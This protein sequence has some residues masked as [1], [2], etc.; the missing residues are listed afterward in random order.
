MADRNIGD[1][2]GKSNTDADQLIT[3]EDVQHFLE[4]MKSGL[5]L[6]QSKIDFEISNIDK[7]HPFQGPDFYEVLKL[8]SLLKNQETGQFTE[9]V[10]SNATISF[11][12][13]P[14]AD[15][16]DKTTITI[17]IKDDFLKSVDA[18]DNSIITDVRKFHII[19]TTEASELTSLTISEVNQ[20]IVVNDTLYYI[21]DN[22]ASSVACTVDTLT[23][24]E[25]YTD[26]NFS[27]N[28]SK[29]KNVNNMGILL[30]SNG[31]NKHIPILK[32]HLE[33]AIN[34][35]DNNL[36][37]DD[38]EFS[39]STD[40]EE[41]LVHFS[42]K[43]ASVDTY[44]KQIVVTFPRAKV[45]NFF[46][47]HNNASVLVDKTVGYAKVYKI[48]DTI[49][50]TDYEL[51]LPPVF[52]NKDADTVPHDINFGSESVAMYGDYIAVS[53][54]YSRPID[55]EEHQP[56]TAKVFLYE[57]VVQSDTADPGY[58][59][60]SVIEDPDFACEPVLE[61]HD[62]T[63]FVS[64]YVG[65]FIK[66]Y[67]I[68]DLKS[69]DNYSK[70][71]PIST[72][73]PKA[74][75]TVAGDLLY[76]SE[77]G[78]SVVCR[79]GKNLFVGAP[80]AIVKY[81]LP[82]ATG[83]VEH[84]VLDSHIDDEPN[85]N[86]LEATPWA[87]AQSI[88][89]SSE[90]LPW[91]A[92]Y[93]EWENTLCGMQ[94]LIAIRASE[95]ADADASSITA[96]GIEAQC[97]VRGKYDTDDNI[98]MEAKGYWFCN[99]NSNEDA[100]G[101][102]IW[103]QTEFIAWWG[104]LSPEEQA[105]Y[106]YYS[107]VD[108]AEEYGEIFNEDLEL[109]Y[110]EGNQ[111]TGPDPID[112]QVYMYV[113]TEFR[114]GETIDAQPQGKYEGSE[115]IPEPSL[116]VKLKENNTELELN[117]LGDTNGSPFYG[118]LDTNSYHILTFKSDSW[119]YVHSDIGYT[120]SKDLDYSDIET[121]ADLIRLGEI[122]NTKY[123]REVVSPT[124]Y[125]GE[126]VGWDRS[127]LIQNNESAIRSP[128]LAEWG[129]D[130]MQDF[131]DDL[132][133][134]EDLTHD[135][136]DYWYSGGDQAY[137]VEG[138]NYR[139]EVVGVKKAQVS[140]WDN[141]SYLIVGA[142]RY[143]EDFNKVD[144]EVKSRT[145][146]AFILDVAYD[147]NQDTSRVNSGTSTLIKRIKPST[148]AP[149]QPI[150]AMETETSSVK[151]EQN[152][153]DCDEVSFHIQ[154]ETFS[155]TEIVNRGWPEFWLSSQDKNK[156]FQAENVKN[157]WKEV[158]G[159]TLLH[160]DNAISSKGFMVFGEVPSETDEEW[161]AENGPEYNTGSILG[162]I[163]LDHNPM[164]S[165]ND[166][167]IT[168]EFWWRTTSHSSA[169]TPP[170]PELGY[171]ILAYLDDT[172][173]ASQYAPDLTE[174][175]TLTYKTAT[176]K[177][178]FKYKDNDPL[179]SS[180]ELPLNAWYH[181]VL[182]HSKHL[183]VS[184][185]TNSKGRNFQLYVNGNP[186]F[187]PESVTEDAVFDK[188]ITDTDDEGNYTHNLFI[189]GVKLNS[190]E[191]EDY[192]W[193]LQNQ[194]FDDIRITHGIRYKKVITN[195]D[196]TLQE[197]GFTAPTSAFQICYYPKGYGADVAMD[198]D[199]DVFV[200][201]NLQDGFIDKHTNIRWQTSSTDT[202]TPID[203]KWTDKVT[204]GKENPVVGG[205]I[206]IYDTDL[207]Y[208][209]IN[210][211][212]IFPRTEDI[213][214]SDGNLEHRL[215]EGEAFQYT[216]APF[217]GSDE[218]YLYSVELRGF[219]TINWPDGSTQ[220]YDSRYGYTKFTRA[221][222]SLGANAHITITGL[223]G[224]G[225]SFGADEGEAKI[226]DVG[227]SIP[228]TLIE[229]KNSFKGCAT[230]NSN[231]IIKWNTQH[232]KSMSGMFSGATA[233]DRDISNW[234]VE[235]V[236]N[237]SGMFKGAT[238]F[239][240]DLSGWCVPLLNE[241]SEFSIDSGLSSEQ[242]P[243]WGTCNNYIDFYFDTTSLTAP[244]VIPFIS[245]V[246]SSNLSGYDLTITWGNNNPE[247]F[248]VENIEQS[249]NNFTNN[250]TA[251]TISALY[252]TKTDSISASS[253]YK[254]RLAL[255]NVPCKLQKI[256]TISSETGFGFPSTLFTSPTKII[257]HRGDSLTEFNCGN[258]QDLEE[259]DLSNAL[260]SNIEYIS[261]SKCSV[262]NSIT[263][264]IN[265]DCIKINSFES[266]FNECDAL[267][268][269]SLENF[270]NTENIE[271]VS[272]M[273][274][275]CSNLT[276]INLSDFTGSN[277]KLATSMFRGSGLST[278]NGENLNTRKIENADGMFAD[279]PNF[280]SFVFG[281]DWN[282][283]NLESAN[284]MYGFDEYQS[285]SLGSRSIGEMVNA[286]GTLPK[287]KS[288]VGFFKNLKQIEYLGW[289][290]NE[291]PT[292]ENVTDMTEMY[293]GA[294]EVDRDVLRHTFSKANT[295]NLK[296]I[297]RMLGC[298]GE[299]N[300]HW[301]DGSEGS[302]T[303]VITDVL[304]IVGNALNTDK[305]THAVG[306][307]QNQIWLTEFDVSMNLA[308]VVDMSNF[309]ENTKVTNPK[310]SHGWDA[311]ELTTANYMFK[312]IQNLRHIFNWD[313]SKLESAIGMFE[314]VTFSYDPG[315]YSNIDTWD[316]KKLK[317]ADAMFKDSNFNEDLFSWC[318]QSIESKESFN[319]SSDLSDEKLPIWDNEDCP[320]DIIILSHKVFTNTNDLDNTLFLPVS[321]GDGGIQID[322]G[323]GEGWE[324]YTKTASSEI[325]EK[326]I[327]SNSGRILIK[328]DLK[329]IAFTCNS[330]VNSLP[331]ENYE[332]LDDGVGFAKYIDPWTTNVSE[333]EW[334]K[335]YSNAYTT[336]NSPYHVN[337]GNVP[338]NIFG[339]DETN[340]SGQQNLQR[341]TIRG[342]SSIISANNM[343]ARTCYAKLDLANWDTSNVISSCKMFLRSRGV[344]DYSLFENDS[345]KQIIKNTIDARHMFAMANYSASQYGDT[346][347][348]TEIELDFQNAK[349]IVALFYQF[350]IMGARRNSL[351]KL[352]KLKLSIPKCKTAHK[353]LAA[354]ETR[355]DDIEIDNS[356]ELFDIND[357]F[358]HSY[359]KTVK[360]KT[361][362]GILTAER[363]FA[364]ARS[365]YRQVEGEN[366]ETII[367]G[368]F[369]SLRLADGMFSGSIFGKLTGINFQAKNLKFAEK[370]FF[371]CD[372]TEIN[373]P[374]MQSK[375]T[376]AQAMFESNN[377]VERC[378]KISFPKISITGHH[379]EIHG[380]DRASYLFKGR[381]VLE[382]VNLKNNFLEPQTPY[383]TFYLRN[384]FQGC[385]Q[386]NDS[387]IC[388][389]DVS[390]V[391][392]FSYMFNKA[393]NFNQNLRKWNV[394]NGL[395]FKYMFA[396]ATS[397]VGY[398]LKNWNLMGGATFSVKKRAYDTYV[399]QN[400][401][402]NFH[403]MFNNGTSFNGDVSNWGNK[404]YNGINGLVTV[405]SYHYSND[406]FS[407]SPRSCWINLNDMFTNA[408]SFNRS[409]GSW[410]N[411]V[412]F[413]KVD[414]G[415]QI[416]GLR[417]TFKGCSS[418]NTDFS[419]WSISK[420]A[421]AEKEY[422]DQIFENSAV[423]ENKK[424]KPKNEIEFY[425][426]VDITISEVSKMNF[427]IRCADTSFTI[428]W[429]DG[430]GEQ[431]ISTTPDT[432][433]MTS[434]IN[435]VA[436]DYG[437]I[438]SEPKVIKIK[439]PITCIDAVLTK[440]GIPANY[441]YDWLSSSSYLDYT[442]DEDLSFAVKKI[443]NRGGALNF[444]GLFQS[445][446]FCYKQSH[447][448]EIDYTNADFTDFSATNEGTFGWRKCNKIR[449]KKHMWVDSVMTPFSGIHN[450]ITTNETATPGVGH[451][452]VKVPDNFDLDQI[453]EDDVN[454]YYLFT[455]SAISNID[456]L[457]NLSNFKN[458][459]NKYKMFSNMHVPPSV[460]KYKQIDFSRTVS[461]GGCF[462]LTRGSE[463]IDM[464]GYD[465]S[466]VV[467]FHE[468]FSM[469]QI[470]NITGLENWNVSNGLRFQS[471]FNGNKT[472]NTNISNWNMS[473]AVDIMNMFRHATAF[474][475]N[476][477]NWDL[478]NCT[479]AS[480][481]LRYTQVPSFKFGKNRVQRVSVG[482]VS[483]S[484]QDG[485]ELESGSDLSF[486]KEIWCGDADLT[487]C[488]ISPFIEKIY[489]HSGNEYPHDLSN[490]KVGNLSNFDLRHGTTIPE[491]KKPKLVQLATRGI[492]NLSQKERV[493]TIL[494][495]F[496]E[497][498]TELSFNVT[499]SGNLK[500]YWNPGEEPEVIDTP[501]TDAN[502]SITQD[503]NLSNVV[504]QGNIEHISFDPDNSELPPSKIKYAL[505][506][507]VSNNIR[508]FDKMFSN[509]QVVDVDMTGCAVFSNRYDIETQI[510]GDRLRLASATQRSAMN[511][512]SNCT[513]LETVDF[514]E[515]IDLIH[516]TF[517]KYYNNRNR[518]GLY[519][520]LGWLT[521]GNRMFSECYQLKKVSFKGCKLFE[522]CGS[523]YAAFWNC[524][525]LSEIILP[526]NQGA[527][528]RADLPNADD[529]YTEF[530]KLS[531][532]VSLKSTFMH[533]WV[534]ESID[535]SSNDA[536]YIS[537]MG[538]AFQECRKLTEIDVSN[539]IFLNR[540]TPY[541]KTVNNSVSNLF[542]RCYVLEKII[543][544]NY[545]DVSSIEIFNHTFRDCEKLTDLSDIN[546]WKHNKS[547]FSDGMLEVRS[548]AGM[549]TN[550]PLLQ[551]I[552]LSKWCIADE[553]TADSLSN[554]ASGSGIE[555]ENWRH[556]KWGTCPSDNLEST[557]DD[558]IL[559]T[560][561]T[562]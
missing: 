1:F 98:P 368:K 462:S 271:N 470:A 268:E 459:K 143:F 478:S 92:R 40:I 322:W 248:S 310:F 400:V 481:M 443:V 103:N 23:K 101:N 373:F 134:R 502:Y 160:A 446:T 353:S 362:V 546:D 361:T 406:D 492:I 136:G 190:A 291:P 464:S 168:I 438:I 445:D 276:S 148:Q 547:H 133:D 75:Y 97:Y 548:V 477:N 344:V 455:N 99:I 121:E 497:D 82:V 56:K 229:F 142:P 380:R 201:S 396:G 544:L 102:K 38:Y 277:V 393:E 325:L 307:L 253:E 185:E 9:E 334:Y 420:Y 523:L 195:T 553:S 236:T 11:V 515:P 540:P 58:K 536:I 419:S 558:I 220:V 331:H 309:F 408:Q 468:M 8:H 237:M 178:I 245:S 456:E 243:N 31:D 350:G 288:L 119:V 5:F 108:R 146:A 198:A 387:S 299:V 551:K 469:I 552:N 7:K 181:I 539:F 207:V 77:W 139:Q 407:F 227:D 234:N 485:A 54:Y 65:N 167:D 311:S 409:L 366:A 284:V 49:D 349:T 494:L 511:M 125:L 379:G 537:Q 267:T 403:G 431:T 321:I 215:S 180:A 104:A 194:H 32:E 117:Y 210:D 404:I 251:E 385:T 17:K 80:N 127:K 204:L 405:S 454:G 21:T 518:N 47:E 161:M 53:A 329:Q 219:G 233:F 55:E 559:P 94:A 150:R 302:D 451:V 461:A 272:H 254:V 265:L 531:I 25:S 545:L 415:G 124:G 315:E 324:T 79:D 376:N 76:N 338:P 416:S 176:N 483:G 313:T 348:P 282:F 398:G 303:K 129:A 90:D 471:M 510:E 106:G 66:T 228:S 206:S 356:D 87:F 214:I 162:H 532:A 113:T 120:C 279:M 555:T 57:R 37:L 275:N 96:S 526:D 212:R 14:R 391:S 550:T 130:P 141:K 524:K 28:D 221:F 63:L 293:Y 155:Q 81:S 95:A 242:V 312:G 256:D 184:T 495:E 151:D 197:T 281:E 261:F 336:Y 292:F 132:Y 425:S 159:E 482:S 111:G 509:T 240:Y 158:P 110:T 441:G 68:P 365:Y 153:F 71:T 320:D 29:V 554:F 372:S 62:E 64:D 351:E 297:N 377:F 52:G 399:S 213:T 144:Q 246:E 308:S 259:V 465:V 463:T 355:F 73:K 137:I 328:G 128:L 389:W 131:T 503:S 418:L 164:Y 44:E 472:F 484:L 235:N 266:L 427:A 412:K 222:N 174:S 452:L 520:T 225:E 371:N 386:F 115:L 154:T 145:G 12:V 549:L 378:K 561:P 67:N 538:G 241:Q 165:F 45:S 91:W 152:F 89:G 491:E 270:K 498:T 460:E 430:D 258:Y 341:I 392:D 458:I 314:G 247:V 107:A 390:C 562:E 557:W 109:Y 514:Y 347:I 24:I 541:F 252:P 100:E 318:T 382:I 289:K 36:H 421:I 332:F 304:E 505:V 519:H 70:P 16:S 116:I 126:C 269:I 209:N 19:D 216:L 202:L 487:T 506:H 428:D 298:N 175:W 499:H 264:P 283:D 522:S 346:E 4:G 2:T 61:I 114:F 189:G 257:V 397:Y 93:A 196:G 112:R 326:N 199:Y 41:T 424:I 224:F 278:I 217:E 273:F 504:I 364:N 51:L 335:D 88:T 363:A 556:P 200:L 500:V 369:N 15:D 218:P 230:F 263:F 422:I 105:K 84:F 170:Q 177:L 516:P 432:R 290:T 188:K 475:Q 208:G 295:I 358:S 244:L 433:S 33:T 287:I 354:L 166:D 440:N 345:I 352:P 173:W 507:D 211:L 447:I 374:V 3:K 39:I 449:L 78:R 359:I 163:K 6:D 401:E 172:N 317:K 171:P 13:H 69:I 10:K 118:K 342:M 414:D 20:L 85:D 343:F 323:L 434:S 333:Y 466:N 157:I 149:E 42:Q 534:L 357:M 527:Y 330:I 525:Q 316:V 457:I 138:E 496:H 301:Q 72:I 381:K 193:S 394:S 535:L 339:L 43:G 239:N 493:A 48:A 442:D 560:T 300:N 530:R 223:T 186:Q 395:N 260:L 83:A 305:V 488:N 439:G 480:E 426:E 489:L 156:P 517:G 34:F 274:Q 529:A 140:D 123:S 59:F 182:V 383:S 340:I 508:S 135:V 179:V 26:Y 280:S 232:V 30:T 486:A 286:M 192:T 413:I 191:F 375:L 50:Y 327:K 74:Q 402:L 203:W 543:G 285:S 423:P 319:E 296:T 444:R 436:V 521:D 501:Q 226:I 86:G 417:G 473:N 249:L 435:F 122:I 367:Q 205:E 467:D 262:L 479:K 448:S 169:G 384:T 450:S 294:N 528:V 437:T 147:V 60:M 512:F 337:E 410:S 27:N 513:R 231:N 533:C 474:N 429:D 187:S 411:I 255:P 183:G 360:F 35:N 46:H 542:N 306:F 18:T 476:L 453:L 388:N 238:S 370:M 250:I 490:L 22:D